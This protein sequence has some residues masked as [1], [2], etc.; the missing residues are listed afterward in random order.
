MAPCSGWRG[1]CGLW[2]ILTSGKLFA[3][4]PVRRKIASV[5]MVA[6][7]FNGVVGQIKN[8][9]RAHNRAYPA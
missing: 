2:N 9:F 6:M 4:I 3:I 1:R 5:W 8:P 7:D